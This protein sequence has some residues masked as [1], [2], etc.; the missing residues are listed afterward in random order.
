MYMAQYKVIQD[1]EAEDKLLGPLT[2]RQFIYSAIVISILY[3]GF[4]IAKT[5][6]WFID[7]LLVPPLIFFGLLAAPFGH[8]QSSEIWL[9]GKVRYMIFS[10]K[11]VWDQ[12]GIEHLV[13]ITVPPKV[14]THYS[15]GL[16]NSDVKSRLKTLAATMDTRGW[17]VKNQTSS[18]YT[19]GSTRYGE[20]GERL[21]EIQENPNE[22]MLSIKPSS[23]VLDSS[24]SSNPVAA[25]LSEKVAASEQQRRRQL[26]ERMQKL[27]EDQK[28]RE[29]SAEPTNY[30]PPPPIIV[31]PSKS[32]LEDERP[33]TPAKVILKNPSKTE[34]SPKQTIINNPP[35]K[36]VT[37]PLDADII[38]S[39]N[40]R[41]LSTD[42]DSQSVNT[43]SSS[44]ESGEVVISLH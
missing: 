11:R 6:V 28:S 19:A 17:V 3:A 20:S 7:F 16:S 5:P 24:A 12:E 36:P 41:K 8:E 15:D 1:I 9:L 27:S 33:S 21:L 10:K 30:T 38:N 39:V 14:E 34:V 31:S 4:V 29:Q 22:E 42:D 37:Q 44:D 2:L 32:P 40:K 26:L 35:P 43:E 18:G 23:D 25:D 13:T